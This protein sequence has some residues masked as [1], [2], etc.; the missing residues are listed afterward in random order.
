MVKSTLVLLTKAHCDEHFVQFL[1]SPEFG[2]EGVR[3]RCFPE[4]AL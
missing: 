3:Q 4:R 1:A 2:D